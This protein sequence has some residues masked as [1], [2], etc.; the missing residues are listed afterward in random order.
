MAADK[1]AK[2][3]AKA[4]FD[5]VS[6][7]GQ[8]E[9]VY[10]DM[11]TII[12]AVNS[13]KELKVF[14]KSPIVKS[15]KKTAALNQI[16]NQKISDAS[17]SLIQLLIEKNREGF[18]DEIAAFYIKLY[19]DFNHILEVKVTT[20]VPL[21]DHTEA[22]IK[23]SIIAKVGDKKLII[24]SIINPD[25]IGGFV[26]DLGSSVFD[27]SVRNKLSNIANELIYN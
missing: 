18:L 16:F 24:K 21:N 7:K 6:S 12:Q 2:R 5:E 27:A 17:F 26:I 15:E 1:L 3:Y 8:L 13:S 25:I 10:S 23:K 14:L 9:T 11:Q 4:L 19:N 20:A 22:E